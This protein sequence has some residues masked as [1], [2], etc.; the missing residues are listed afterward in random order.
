MLKI[1]AGD[2]RTRIRVQNNAPERAPGSIT[3]TDHWIDLGNVNETDPPRYKRCQW[4]GA[5]GSEG[6]ADGLLEAD[7][8]ATIRLRYDSRITP[9]CRILLNGE[10]WA[11]TGVDDV[12]QLHRW[13]EIKVERTVAG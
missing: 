7:Q 11:I 13:M 9:A 2:L 6:F 3:Q 12:R 5:H 10:P 8:T 4:I 1:S